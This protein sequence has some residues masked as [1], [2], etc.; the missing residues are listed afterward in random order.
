ME[1]IVKITRGQLSRLILEHTEEYNILSEGL[2]DVFTSAGVSWAKVKPLSVRKKIGKLA[3]MSDADVATI[4]SS[5]GNTKLEKALKDKDVKALATQA[6][7]GGGS[8]TGSSA[9]AAQPGEGAASAAAEDE[10]Q[11][12]RPQ[13]TVAGG[14]EGGL[15]TGMM[16]STRHAEGKKTK[17]FGGKLKNYQALGDIKSDFGPEFEEAQKKLTTAP[18]GGSV[19]IGTKKRTGSDYITKVYVKFTSPQPVTK[20]SI[21]SKNIK[22]IYLEIGKSGAGA[23]KD[24]KGVD[25]WAKALAAALIFGKGIQGQDPQNPR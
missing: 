3:G 5:A 2:Y 18:Y 17:K 24:Y 15:Q 22:E 8:S 11:N 6:L 12:Q 23:V 14:E 13:R 1:I 10:E 20:A 25:N 9:G 4:G 16:A 19:G 21:T 7:G